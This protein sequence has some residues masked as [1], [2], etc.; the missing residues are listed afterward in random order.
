MEV[1]MSIN[2]PR[3]S[4]SVRKRIFRKAIIALLALG[5]P[6]LLFLFQFGIQKAEVIGESR[7]TD[8]QIR[9]M[10]LES[11]LDYNSVYL[12]LKYRFF[13]TPDIP[14]IEKLDIEMNSRHEVTIYV[15]EK[16]VTGC[17][18]VMGEYMY[19]DKDGIIVESSS[20]KVEKVPVIEGLQFRDIV[21]HDKLKLLD[22]EQTKEE[23]S[24]QENTGGDT[25]S[26]EE[27]SGSSD[28]QET[29]KDEEESTG[30]KDK[31]F[32]IILNLTKLINKYELDVD[33]VRFDENN[34]VTLKCGD[35]RV[36]LGKKNDYEVAL[37]DLKNILAKAEGTKA[38]ELDMRDYSKESN[39]VIGKSKD[40]TE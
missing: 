23:D 20:E 11:R 3:S 24:G 8:Q 17:V 21:L 4:N 36:L 22:E 40:S 33:V 15:Y 27:N 18:Y 25:Q 32:D 26:G 16:I 35:I 37:S 14:F 30:A 28:E 6:M 9:D 19:F 34:N 12:Y 39:Y 29:E 10:V 31:L 7:Y 38:Y 2:R 5:I 1:Q 13:T